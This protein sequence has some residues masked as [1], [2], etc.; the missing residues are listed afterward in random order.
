MTLVTFYAIHKFRTKTNIIYITKSI[1]KSWVM[2]GT[3]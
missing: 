1:Y 2:Y 3:L